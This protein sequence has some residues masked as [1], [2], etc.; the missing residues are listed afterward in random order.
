MDSACAVEPAA[1]ERSRRG[2]RAAWQ[3]VAV[4]AAARA[5]VSLAPR[6]HRPPPES[7]AAVQPPPA[8]RPR[9]EKGTYHGLT[10]RQCNQ[11]LNFAMKHDDS[12]AFRKPVDPERMGLT[13]Y[14]SIVKEPM[15]LETI[16]QKLASSRYLPRPSRASAASASRP[17]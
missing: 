7:M 13:D 6:E 5:L 9:V 16:E 14:R 3:W 15:D 8:K 4:G 12:W 17:A 10:M 11:L 1:R 2:S